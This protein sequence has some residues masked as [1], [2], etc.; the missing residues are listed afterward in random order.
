[1]IS[2][3]TELR[4]NSSS[5]P[6]DSWRSSSPDK[7]FART[8]QRTNPPPIVGIDVS[9]CLFSKYSLVSHEK[10]KEAQQRMEEMRQLISRRQAEGPT[11]PLNRPRSFVGENTTPNASEAVNPMVFTRLEESLA[12]AD[13]S[14]VNAMSHHETLRNDLEQFILE[15]KEVSSNSLLEFCEPMVYLEGCG[16]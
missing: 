10:T 16:S 14:M 3:V 11:T 8:S 6:V 9:P 1:M 2:Y 12:D 7:S 15:I 5:S 4:S 13:Q